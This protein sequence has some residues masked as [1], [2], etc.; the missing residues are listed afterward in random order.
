MVWVLVQNQ[1]RK[2]SARAAR[3]CVL[4][5]FLIRDRSGPDDRHALRGWRNTP[6]LVRPPDYCGLLF[7]L[8]GWFTMVPDARLV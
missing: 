5:L 6:R 1:P 7:L 4:L 2:L 3:E 8:F